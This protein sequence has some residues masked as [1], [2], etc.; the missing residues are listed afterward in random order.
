MKEDYEYLKLLEDAK[1]ELTVPLGE[2]I[3]FQLPDLDVLLEGKTTIVRNFLQIVDAINRDAQHL[4]VYLL[5]EIG[6]PGLLDENKRLVLKARI[7]KE[8][9]LR[10]IRNYVDTYVLCSE[11]ERPDTHLV[12]E[13]R[14]LLLIC[15]ACG[16]QRP[17]LV[18]KATRSADATQE[19]KRGQIIEVTVQDISQRGDGVARVGK[20]VIFVP[21]T[22]KGDRVKVRIDH[23]S[24]DKYVQS[25]PLRE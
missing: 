3:R 8:D 6:A 2:H 21:G 24:N 22:R 23:V 13:G 1:K 5:R 11:C 25:T 15:D 9:L 12:K 17:V 19:L 4:L 10:R 7:S 20:Y 18:R 14:I 16:A